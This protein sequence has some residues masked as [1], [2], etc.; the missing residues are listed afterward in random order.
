[1]QTSIYQ[2]H[3]AREMRTEVSQV[4]LLVLRLR[5][6]VRER[7]LVLEKKLAS[8]SGNEVDNLGKE[9]TSQNTLRSAG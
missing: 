6:E 7:N 4:R 5:A 9:V 1:M 3:L 2:K 8:V